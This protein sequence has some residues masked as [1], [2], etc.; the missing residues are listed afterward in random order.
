MLT[1]MLLSVVFVPSRAT[2]VYGGKQ[3]SKPT[4]SVLFSGSRRSLRLGASSKVLEKTPRQP[5]RVTYDTRNK[6]L[7]G[8]SAVWLT[9][10]LAGVRW[11]I[12]RCH[13][14]APVPGGSR[15]GSDQSLQVPDGGN[16]CR[17]S[18]RPDNDHRQLHHALLQVGVADIKWDVTDFS[19]LTIKMFISQRRC[20]VNFKF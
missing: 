8:P 19:H 3:S 10:L 6:K 7:H 2:S 14:A 11:W 4:N 18:V 12:Q 15:S 17:V 9:D 1:L 5:V 13:P 20:R 16:I